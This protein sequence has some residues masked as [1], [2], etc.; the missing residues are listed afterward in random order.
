VRPT[1]WRWEFTDG[2]WFDNQ[3]ATLTLNSGSARLAI[4]KAVP[5]YPGPA[6]LDRVLDRPLT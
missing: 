1:A 4:D 2:P 3:V 5:H 6:G